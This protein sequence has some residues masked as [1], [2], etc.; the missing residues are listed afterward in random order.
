MLAVARR[1]YAHSVLELYRL[2]PERIGPL[3]STDRSLAAALH[4]Q[5][6]PL[7]IVAAALLLGVVRRCFRSPSAQPLDP[8]ATLHYF[9][10]VIAE[11]IAQPPE[12]DYL[13]YLRHRVASVAP[14][15]AAALT[16]QLP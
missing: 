9:R 1:Q 7:E 16:H 13:A 3:R 11:I 15:F 6:I 8:I 2:V 10:P 14:R 4:D 5:G 12:P